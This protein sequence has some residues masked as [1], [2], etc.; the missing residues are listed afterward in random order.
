MSFDPTANKIDMLQQTQSS[1]QSILGEVSGGENSSSDIVKL[2]VKSQ[3]S[4]SER[5]CKR[6]DTILDLKKKLEVITGRV[7]EMKLE[8]IVLEGKYR[9]FCG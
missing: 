1:I 4:T 3:F 2:F 7:V 9:T 8:N 5:R 6:S